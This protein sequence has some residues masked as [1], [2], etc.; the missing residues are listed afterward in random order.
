MGMAVG[1]LLW[2][3]GGI[4][5]AVCRSGPAVASAGVTIGRVG[6]SGTVTVGG[7]VRVGK[8]GVR[9]VRRAVARVDVSDRGVV[10]RRAR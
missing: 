6:V 4:G 3:G 5:V 2:G 9:V 10:S 1:V 7:G 8:K